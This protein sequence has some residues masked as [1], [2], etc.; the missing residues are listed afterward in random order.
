MKQIIENPQDFQIV[1]TQVTKN[2]DQLLEYYKGNG[3][4][5]QGQ[6]SYHVHLSVRKNPGNLTI[7]KTLVVLRVC[8]VISLLK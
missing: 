7:T 1:Y 6:D 8:Q 3:S 5:Q 4:L 2:H